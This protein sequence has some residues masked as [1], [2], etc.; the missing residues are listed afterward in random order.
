MITI[1]EIKN[2]TIYITGDEKLE[3]LERVQEKQ[4]ETGKL[5]IARTSIDGIYTYGLEQTLGSYFGHGPGYIWSSRASVINSQ[6]DTVLHEAAYRE[7]D[8]GY[9]SCAVDLIRFEGILKAH[10][11]KIDLNKP[12]VSDDGIDI[13]YK[14]EKISE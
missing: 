3:Y 8:R 11:Y 1:D 5:F 6:L 10:G 12:E 4:C 13:H 9:R 7:G 2:G 14:V